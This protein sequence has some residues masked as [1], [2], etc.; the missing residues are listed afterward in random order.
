MKHKI[1]LTTIFFIGALL[2][3]QNVFGPPFDPPD[4]GGGGPVGVPIDG[5][6]SALIAA[7]VA[8]VVRKFR[9]ER[10]KKDKTE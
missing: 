3:T 5:G 10:K 9:K 7:G 1:I 2:I 6:I 8:L 4:G